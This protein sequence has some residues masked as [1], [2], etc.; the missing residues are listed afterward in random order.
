MHHRTAGL[1]AEEDELGR[2][3]RTGWGSASLVPPWVLPEVN[4]VSCSH[5]VAAVCASAARRHTEAGSLGDL[6]D[7]SAELVAEECVIGRKSRER[8]GCSL[9]VPSKA[10]PE[11]WR[12]PRVADAGGA[13]HHRSAGR[14]VGEGEPGRGLRTV[15]G[16]VPLVPPW[17]LH[18][19][20]A[21]AC[22]QG[23][24]AGCSC[25]A[26]RHTETG[27]L[28]ALHDRSA[29]LVAEEI[30]AACSHGVAAVCDSAPRRHTDAGGLRDLHDRSAELVAEECV[31]G[32][33]TGVRGGWFLR[34]PSK[35]LPKDCHAPGYPQGRFAVSALIA[36]FLSVAD[37]LGQAFRVELRPLVVPVAGIALRARPPPMPGEGLRSLPTVFFCGCLPAAAP[38]GAWRSAAPL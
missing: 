25:A 35:A 38:R 32:R 23:V 21:A 31:I 28:G 30:A 7:R 26:K 27:R 24:A 22:S 33:F 37:R 2:G 6:H 19:V 8:G 9:R 4:A 3:L 29:E 36:G 16:S 1:V 15:W 14:V 5:G 13:V 34:M 12:T 20:F 18:E 10:L 11:D 17:V